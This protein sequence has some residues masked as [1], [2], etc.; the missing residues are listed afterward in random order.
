MEQ[1]VREILEGP[2]FFKCERFRITMKKQICVDRQVKR[3]TVGLSEHSNHLQCLDCEQ[4]RQIAKELGAKVKTSKPLDSPDKPGN[5]EK[6]SNTMT[7]KKTC[8]DCG[9]EKVLDDFP[10][11]PSYRDGHTNKCKACTREYQKARLAKKN[12][13]VKPDTPET[14]VSAEVIEAPAVQESPINNDNGEVY[15]TAAALFIKGVERKL[16]DKI[17]EELKGSDD[18]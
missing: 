10:K 13:T 17:V 18:A 15:N 7:D 9:K 12:G 6:G 11:N 3:K 8:N 5:D 14:A 1:S 4:G 2:D 16:M